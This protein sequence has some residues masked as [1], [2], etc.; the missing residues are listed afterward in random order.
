L[1]LEKFLGATPADDGRVRSGPHTDAE[2]EAGYPRPHV[3]TVRPV[4]RSTNKLGERQA[5]A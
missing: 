1:G 5:R 4:D 3:R 2:L